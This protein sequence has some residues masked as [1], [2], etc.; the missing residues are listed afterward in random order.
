MTSPQSLCPPI[1]GTL[2]ARLIVG[3]ASCEIYRISQNDAL[4]GKSWS[5]NYGVWYFSSPSNG[6]SE[7]L[8]MYAEEAP[9][10]A[11][12]NRRLGA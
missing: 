1:V 6:A 2:H 9:A 8:G 3:E 11:R 12:A 4:T 10:L 7:F 5:E